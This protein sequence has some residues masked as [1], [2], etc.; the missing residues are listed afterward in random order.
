MDIAAM[1]Q[2]SG[3]QQPLLEADLAPDPIAQFE[4]WLA[5]AVASGEPEPNAMTL[6]T[7]QLADD[8][9]AAPDAR[10]VLLK[11]VGP[12][13]FVFFSNYA[14]NKGAQLAATPAASLVFWWPSCQRQVR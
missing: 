11:G 5:E 2:L 12:D 1:R 3:R 14:S 10:M 13:G 6:A 9:S 4:Q 8:G 7:V